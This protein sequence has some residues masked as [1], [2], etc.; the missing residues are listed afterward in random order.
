MSGTIEN[1]TIESKN[2]IEDL[3]SSEFESPDLETTSF[4]PGL[5]NTQLFEDISPQFMA[6]INQQRKHVEAGNIK[7]APG[8]K[9]QQL[10]KNFNTRSPENFP[11][12]E[13]KK[14]FY[15]DGN[16]KL[17]SILGEPL[18]QAG[19]GSCWAF[20]TA[21]QFS[22]V[23]RFNLMRIYGPE[24]APKRS[25]FFQP[26][27]V[28]TGEADIAT[29]QG[30]V[31][32]EKIKVYAEETDF[33][34]STYFTVAFSPKIKQMP[35]GK[36][37]LDSKCNDALDEWKQTITT[38]GRAP[39]DLNQI[40]LNNFKGCMGCQGNLI[41]C[42]LMMFAAASE[43][44]P[45]AVEGVPLSTDF[46]L[47]EWAC[48]WGSPSLKSKFCS[49]EFLR[50]EIAYNFPKL[51]K[52]DYY[53][54]VT[55]DKPIPPNIKAQGINKMSEWMMMAIYNYGPITIGF[56]V[57][58]S[59]LKFFANKANANKIYT[60][61]Q[62]AS[63]LRQ[64]GA[65]TKPLGGHA[66]V[67]VGWDESKE[68]I[69]YWIVRNSWGL[70][71]ADHGYFSMERDIDIKLAQ[72]GVQQRV[73]FD[74]EFGNLYFSP[75][76]QLLEGAPTNEMKEFLLTRPLAF[77]PTRGIRPELVEYMSKQCSCRCGLHYDKEK[78]I[79]EDK[80]EGHVD[81]TYSSGLDNGFGQ[82]QSQDQLQLNVNTNNNNSM[83]TES[84]LYRSGQ[85]SQNGTNPGQQQQTQVNS[86]NNL[87]GAYVD[88]IAL[89]K[90]QASKTNKAKYF[91]LTI[92]GLLLAGAI[93]Y[94]LLVKPKVNKYHD[95]YL[96]SKQ[97]IVKV[98]DN[99]K[100]WITPD[101][102]DYNSYDY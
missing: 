7:Y 83:I 67:I 45:N 23:I 69:P 27:I 66:V 8:M 63:D 71:W 51:Y 53:S 42:P 33:G 29:S 40:L 13:L 32:Q 39:R 60:A 101:D 2:P 64:P 92:L 74:Y 57:Y 16:G 35:N 1:P 100:W 52:A 26:S 36:T 49:P 97:K 76:P 96:S 22:D 24:D 79:C 70:N 88:G 98:C 89:A 90:K 48:L 91:F 31:N 54:Y 18:D 28:C 80:S 3:N 58:E 15:L 4:I 99:V 46:P 11:E 37:V 59:F 87:A 86:T 93:L 14:W 77:P 44:A 73:R 47:H 61:Q 17:D 43:E 84:S 9:P 6:D 5:F 20:S 21:S 50:G 41:I 25:I 38:K 78:G 10:P 12:N 94:K 82:D 30:V 34:V 75:Y 56:S 85:V 19:C 62:F 65:N 72:L 68:G 81:G 95:A 102:C 55:A